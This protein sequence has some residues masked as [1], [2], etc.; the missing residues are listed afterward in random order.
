MIKGLDT[1]QS[2][3]LMPISSL[4]GNHG[5]GDFGKD[6]YKFA[7]QT[8][9]AGFSLWQILPLNPVGYGNSPYQPYSSFAGDEI[10]ISLE[11]LK[12]EGL[13]SSSFNSKARS[14]EVDYEAVREF[15]N[16]YLKEA[17]E[18]FKET[19]KYESEYQDF[20]KKA[21]WLDDYAK[22]RVLKAKNNNHAW[23]TWP[24]NDKKAV[25][26]DKYQDDTAYH[27]FL[28]FMF[29]KQWK[30]LKQYANELGLKIV[31]DIPIYVG[32]DSSDVWANQ[33]AFKL[34][35]KGNPTSVA[36]VPPD[37]F[38]EFGQLWGNP[39]YDWEYLKENGYN[40]W[41]DRF[42]WN[43]ELFDIIRIDHFRAFDTYWEI[44][45]GEETAVNGEW[46]LGPAYDFFDTVFEKL[47]EL[48]II[49][50]DLGDLRDEVLELRDHYSML[51]MKIAE[52]SFGMEEEEEGFMLPENCIVYTGTHDNDTSFGWFES[53]VEDDK[54]QVREYL[55]NSK[56]AI[57]WALIRLAWAS[58]ARIA[59]APMQ[60]FLEL[61][62][63]HRMNIPGTSENN[64]KWK[65]TS[66]SLN[67]HLAEKIKRLNQIYGR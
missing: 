4:P 3:I 39:I 64:W 19:N 33:K 5:I 46:I 34:D 48:K 15:K 37:Y 61:G 25:D 28:Q 11:K 51:G 6:A 38:S 65:L 21:Y 14:T 29:L 47:P 23:Q 16:K 22:F 7:K 58:A 24:D 59:I 54:Q 52:F 27:K 20:V 44:P 62:S 67:S 26:I 66:G 57:S 9:K 17:Y 43:M 32:S 56:E 10:Y 2:G 8:A 41:I 31:G 45:A 55:G 1:R 63:E 35:S 50:E 49:A 18:A 60:D 36:G 12:D 42:S 13:I 30:Q 40:F 53:L